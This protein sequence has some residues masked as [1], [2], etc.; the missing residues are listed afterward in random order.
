MPNA[1]ARSA[2]TPLAT[3]RRASD[4]L[5]E[6]GEGLEELAEVEVGVDVATASTPPVTG[7]LSV[8]YIAGR[9]SL[10][11]V[12]QEIWGVT[13]GRFT[14]ADGLRSGQERSSGIP[15]GRGVN[16]TARIC[17]FVM[18]KEV[19][20]RLDTYPTIPAPQCCGAL[21]KN[22]TAVAMIKYM[23]TETKRQD[24]GNVSLRS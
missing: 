23:P 21:Q 10:T 19:N 14:G 22:Q 12:A 5:E 15:S 20:L 3:R 8:T 6:L 2:K 7:P 9:I 24:D 17:R 16:R 13:H 4:D 1:G 18:I 11:C